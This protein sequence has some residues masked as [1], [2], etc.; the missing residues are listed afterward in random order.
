[1]RRKICGQLS[2]YSCVSLIQAKVKG[3]SSSGGFVADGG[4]VSGSDESDASG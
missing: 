2:E 1:M 3:F 4:D